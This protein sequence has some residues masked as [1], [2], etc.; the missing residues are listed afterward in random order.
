MASYLIEGIHDGIL[1]DP[2]I[3]E[4]RSA[5]GAIG[6]VARTRLTARALTAREAIK[7]TKDGVVFEDTTAK[8]DETEAA[9]SAE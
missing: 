3:V 6:H 8:D 4:C 2:I 7:L 9:D 5:A 1:I